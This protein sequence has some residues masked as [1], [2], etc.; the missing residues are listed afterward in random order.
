MCNIICLSL[1]YI[2]KYRIVFYYLY[3]NGRLIFAV[4]KSK[5]PQAKQ[6]EITAIDS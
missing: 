2:F 5:P 6:L 1:I 4:L 3:K